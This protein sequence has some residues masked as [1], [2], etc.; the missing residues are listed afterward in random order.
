L[1]RS[2]EIATKRLFQLRLADILH[3]ILNVLVIH[4]L[5]LHHRRILI[6]FVRLFENKVGPENFAWL[7]G[8]SLGEEDLGELL[9]ADDRNLSFLRNFE[10]IPTVIL[11][12]NEANHVDEVL[13]P[14]NA[15]SFCLHEILITRIFL[16][17]P[18]HNDFSD[19]VLE[20]H[21]AR[22]VVI[23]RHFRVSEQI[24]DLDPK[25]IIGESEEPQRLG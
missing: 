14:K 9:W 16:N 11:S 23:M 22:F 7:Q 5:I 21:S 4:D 3:D 10:T 13:S 25:L 6:N 17:N 20:I 15:G 1:S 2:I 19:L 18:S 8:F 12:Q 24:Q